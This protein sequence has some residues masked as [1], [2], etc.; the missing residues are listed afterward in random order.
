[1]RLGEMRSG[2]GLCEVSGSGDSGC[3]SNGNSALS[4]CS[5]NGNS[6]R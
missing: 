6:V 4:Y 1:M 5:V 3:F 2:A